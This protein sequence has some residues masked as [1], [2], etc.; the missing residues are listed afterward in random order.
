MQSLRIAVIGGGTAGLASSILLARDHH[1][2]DLFETLAKPLPI[3]SGILL[4]PQGLYALK[5]LDLLDG[6]L[7]VGSRVNALQGLSHRGRQIM[8]F[9]YADLEPNLFAVGIHRGQLFQQLWDAAKAAQVNIRCDHNITHLEQREQVSLSSD[10]QTYADYDLVII[11]NGTWSKLRQQLNI[12]YKK[13]LYPWGAIWSIW[14][15]IEQRCHSILD[16]RYH[17]ASTMIGLLPTGQP[18]QQKHHCVSFFWSL[19]AKRY[20]DWKQ[21]SFQDWRNSNFRLWPELE[22]F[23]PA[24]TTHE[25]FTFARYAD[26]VMTHWH[27]G[28]TVV[29]G[30]AAHAMSP[31]LGQG[32]NMALTDAV[33]LCEELKTHQSVENALAAYS[34]NRRKHLKYYQYA[35]RMLTPFFQS[36][37]RLLGWMRDLVFPPM[38]YI[39]LA[40][41]HALST[42]TGVK[43]SL[44]SNKPIYDLKDISHKLNST[45]TINS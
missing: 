22:D 2:V 1:Q 6:I 26:V 23:W 25:D 33:H 45:D 38:K 32:A 14:S 12:P 5:K 36:N 44:L 7:K 39:P 43:P 16:Q 28:K 11:A 18:P 13:R 3:G 42:L 10:D 24:H 15:D 9:H 40:K 31:Q 20:D 4:Q 17:H 21:Q 37:S 27:D 30:D 35:S 41:K 34:H 8:D 29:I 19:E